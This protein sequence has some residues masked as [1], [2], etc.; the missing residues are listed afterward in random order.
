LVVPFEP[1]GHREV[2]LVEGQ[3]LVVRRHVTGIA[4]DEILVVSFRIQPRHPVDADD[5][6]ER[7]AVA[8]R[9]DRS[10]DFG[11]NEHSILVVDRKLVLPVED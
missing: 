9:V 1:A 8:L 10:A 4:G 6:E 11:W 2:H 7:R 5:E 3:L